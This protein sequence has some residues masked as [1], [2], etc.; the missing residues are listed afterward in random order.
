MT[1]IRDCGA[2][3][4]RAVRTVVGISVPIALLAACGSPADSRFAAETYDE[5]KEPL[6]NAVI[7]SPEGVTAIAPAVVPAANAGAAASDAGVVRGPDGGVFIGDGGGEP[8]DAGPAGGFGFWHFDD[9]S[10]TSNFL[11]DSSG[12]GANAQHALNGSCVPG[13]TGLGVNIRT[14]KDVV[15][16]P[17]EPQFT[18]GQRVGVAAWVHPNTVAGDQPIVI[19]RLNNQTAFSLG[20]HNGNVEM[21]VVLTTG[22]TVI[23]RAPIQPGVWSHVGGMFDGTFVF[24][25][26]D[27][28]QFGQVFGAGTIRN[29]FAPLRI[30]ATTQSQHFDGIIDD[31]FVTTEPITASAITSLACIHQPTTFSVNPAVGG[32]VPFDTTVHF[33]VN[34]N[35]NDVGFCP[36]SQFE[37]FVENVDSTITTSVNPVVSAAAPGQSIDF[38]V[39][40]TPTDDTA[41]GTH[42]LPFFVVKFGTSFEELLGDL[43]LIVEKPAGCFVSTPEELM[44]RDLSVV[45][46]PVRTFGQG[47]QQ[48]GGG[49]DGGATFSSTTATVVGGSTGGFGSGGG[50]GTTSAGSSFIGASSGSGSTRSSASTSVF[51]SS[52]SSSPLVDGGS[53][54]SLRVWTFGQLMKNLAPTEDQAAAMTENLF[55]NWLSDQVVNGFTVAARPAMQTQVLDIW[56]RTPSGALDLDRAPLRLQAIVNRVDLRDLSVG[57]AGEGRFVFAFDDGSGFPQQF[58]VILEYNLPAQ[59]PQDVADWANA[60]HALSSHPFPSEEYNAALEAITRRFMGRGVNP[61]GVNGSAL[62]QLRTNE[63]ALSTDFR[64]QLREFALSP[65]TGFF[66]E[67][68]VRETPDLGFNGTPALAS[69]I[70]ANSAAI[71]AE[72]PGSNGNTI[73]LALPDGTPFRAGAVFNDLIE[74]NAPGIQSDDDRFHTSVD[75]CNGCHG[76]DTGTAFLQITPR[77]PGQG[78]ATLSPFLTGVTVTDLNNVTRTLN[79]LGRRRSDLT[80]LVCADAGAPPP[81][82]AAPPPVVDAGAPPPPAPDAALSH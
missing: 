58:T 39:D 9:C 72:L 22:T 63:I 52:A 56:P 17:D 19:K 51:S 44:I 40:V 48:L 81:P 6:T 37:T 29:V 23:S 50:T 15:Q 4:K 45:D 68:T 30:G 46:D 10:P 42:E 21:S 41:P 32:P 12:E 28:Q 54:P 14:A 11:V 24:L 69:F 67:Q 79:D 1:S 43:T 59:T 20:I 3:L 13:I 33:D 71:E 78:E 55:D 31:V 80:S 73:P 76:P 53:S 18:V 7:G 77:F 2:F 74:W 64:W 8:A 57:S 16:V 70:N 36:T 35:D 25:F 61:S 34:V 47:V 38:G 75:T 5:Y 26:I 27:G 62:L 60:W 66:Q 65:T 82:D 49:F